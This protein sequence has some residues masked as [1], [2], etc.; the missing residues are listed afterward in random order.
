MKIALNL[1]KKITNGIIIYRGPSQIN[2]EPIVVVATGLQS[3]SK[4]VKTGNIVQT[5][6]LV[7]G[8]KPSTAVFSGKDAAVC[9]DCPHRYI[10][11]NGTC[12]VNPVHGPNGVMRAVESNN[13]ITVK[14]EDAA[15]MLSGRIVR[16]G[17]Y[18]DPAAVPI[19]VWNSILSKSAGHTGYTHQW[20]HATANGLQKY[21]MAS[22]ESFAEKSQANALGWRTFRIRTHDQP[23]DK[24]E[25]ICPASEESGK[26]LT[27]EQCKACNGGRV[28]KASVTIVAHGVRWKKQRLLKMIQGQY[29]KS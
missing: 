26:R 23:L 10:D 4:N 29:A 2:G 18:G 9:G 22:V 16:L 6:I 27:C 19:Y 11:G 13:Y 21:C 28:Q 24:N 7:D 14:L 12:Y 20:R 5:Y 17:S 25:I 15:N 3:S 1:V 8:I